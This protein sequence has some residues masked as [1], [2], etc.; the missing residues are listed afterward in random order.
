[1]PVINYSK[2][3]GNDVNFIFHSFQ[4]RG[5]SVQLNVSIHNFI[6]EGSVLFQKQIRLP[7]DERD[8]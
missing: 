6:R 4:S 3:Q 1:M 5:F 7:V 8:I 2:I